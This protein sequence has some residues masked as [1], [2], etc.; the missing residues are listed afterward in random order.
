MIN[1]D[2]TYTRHNPARWF[3][4]KSAPAGRGPGILFRISTVVALLASTAFGQLTY[5]ISN[6]EVVI[7]GYAGELAGHLDIPSTIEG[8]PVTA[9]ADSTCMFRTNLTSLKIPDSVRSIGVDAF[10]LCDKLTNVVFGNGV[11]NISSIAFRFCT[12]LRDV[13]IP[14]SVTS[15]GNYAFSGCYSMTNVF[16]RGDAPTAG[17]STFAYVQQNIYRRYGTSGWPP[18]GQLWLSKTTALWRAAVSGVERSAEGL[19]I[20]IAGPPDDVAVVET[21]A[22]PS[23]GNW[24]PVETNILSNGEGEFIVPESDEYTTRC[25]RVVLKYP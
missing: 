22:T 25:F 15:I 19:R 12:A 16:F 21:C 23:T 1:G 6:N 20:H 7:T 17:P 11:R 18:E 13:V 9:I 14:L 24:T 5:T 8:Y 10:Y 2:T 3:H 4:V